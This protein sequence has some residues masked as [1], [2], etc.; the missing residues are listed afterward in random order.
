MVAADRDPEARCSL[1]LDRD[2]KA[3][4]VVGDLVA[5]DVDRIGQHGQWL[6]HVT[7]TTKP[8]GRALGAR[9]RIAGARPGTSTNDM[10]MVR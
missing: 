8:P 3:A 7:R 4:S 9:R 1:A 10:V 5:S 2:G 6:R